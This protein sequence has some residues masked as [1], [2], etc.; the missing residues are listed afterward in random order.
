MQWNVFCENVNAR[1]IE[2]YNIFQH[3]RFAEDVAKLL[4]EDISKEKFSE[5]LK[6]TL[7]Y[8]FRAKC[9]WETVI[10]SWPVRIDKEELDRLNTEYEESNRKYGRY[11]YSLCTDPDIGKKIDVYD[12]V[13]LNWDVF[14]DYVWKGKK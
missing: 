12:Q 14:V 10:T 7:G 3:G 11:P 5:K 6:R 1:K 8:Y 4:K 13:V 2:M 9:E